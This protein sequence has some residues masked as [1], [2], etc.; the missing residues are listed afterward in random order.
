MPA[1]PT[2]KG[3]FITGTDT[4]VGK[5]VVTAALG[6]ALRRTGVDVG[7][8]KPVE[9]GYTPDSRK[10]TSDGCRLRRSVAPED[11]IELVSPYCFPSPTA[12]L[13]A[14]RLAGQTIECHA[15][16]DTYHALAG[17][18]EFMLVEGVGGILV[19]LTETHDVRALL[20]RLNLPC[21][22]VSRTS[23]GSINHARLTLMAL[24]ER[25]IPIAGVVLNHTSAA[26]T[27]PDERQQIESTVQ[28]IRELSGVPVPDPLPFHSELAG[29][30]DTEIKR[31]AKDSTIQELCRTLID[32]IAHCS[33]H[34]RGIKDGGGHGHAVR[35]GFTD[36]LKGLD[37]DSS[38]REH[39]QR[40]EGTNPA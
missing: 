16:L 18:H 38:D 24:R 23:S 7:V 14:A 31:V 4:N 36:R 29:Q 9:T 20:M 34:F 2:P 22:V 21:L 35:S 25:R 11:P 27:T 39:G 12:P 1:P 6:L 15:I 17:R 13:H 3:L 8:M 28:L 19:P 40:G 32:E 33:L 10:S 30:W 26:A 5:T 37:R